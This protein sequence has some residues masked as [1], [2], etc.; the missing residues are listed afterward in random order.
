MGR[1]KLDPEEKKVPVGTLVPKKVLDTVGR[2]NAI[3]LSE[4]VIMKEFKRITK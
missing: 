4:N 1:K 2:D 3:Q